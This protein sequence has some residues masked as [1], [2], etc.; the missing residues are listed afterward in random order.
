MIGLK[1]IQVN[2]I[3]KQQMIILTLIK[4]NTSHDNMLNEVIRN[5]KKKTKKQKQT[6]FI[7]F[8]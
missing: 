4:K 2:H 3:S 1:L 7:S 8:I 6:I 5:L